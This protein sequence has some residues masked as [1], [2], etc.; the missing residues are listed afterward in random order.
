MVHN[1][2][3][4]LLEHNQHPRGTQSQGGL[5]APGGAQK[6]GKPK[7]R[8]DGGAREKKRREGTMNKGEV[9]V[10]QEWEVGRMT[11]CT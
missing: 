7:R 11:S 2:D 6:G 5:V 1:N 9:L 4:L 3:T 10:E 8:G